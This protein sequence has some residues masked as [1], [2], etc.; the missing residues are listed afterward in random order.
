MKKLIILVTLH[1]AAVIGASA[2]PLCVNGG[3]LAS[4]QSLGLGGCFY[5][6][7]FLSNFAFSAS[8]SGV[9]QAIASSAV[10]VNLVNSSGPGLSFVGAFSVNGISTTA[11]ATLT[12]T[13]T[14]TVSAPSSYLDG[15]QAIVHNASVD[16]R[17]AAPNSAI[18][19]VKSL[20]D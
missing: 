19:F 12:Y 1:L 17:N 9:S 11:S 4:Y 10:T 7:L 8:G 3:S 16:T 5:N 13:L 2:A 6:D 15:V 20:K 14:Y 18:N